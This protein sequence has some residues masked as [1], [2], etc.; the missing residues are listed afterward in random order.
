MGVV[1]G[2]RRPQPPYLSSILLKAGEPI[3]KELSQVCP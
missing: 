2:L 3:K 1:D